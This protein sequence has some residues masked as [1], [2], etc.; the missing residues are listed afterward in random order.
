MI[1]NDM[2]VSSRRL[3]QSRRNRILR[4]A[5]LITL[6]LQSIPTEEEMMES[7][8]MTQSEWDYYKE[9]YFK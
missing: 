2:F 9:K 4:K 3:P 6:A 8:R 1:L 7:L 5:R